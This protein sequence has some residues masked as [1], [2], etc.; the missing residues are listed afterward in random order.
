MHMHAG[1]QDACAHVCMHVDDDVCVR[2]VVCVHP[3]VKGRETEGREREGGARAGGGV[4][5]PLLVPAPRCPPAE[6]AGRC[7][8]DRV[9]P[10]RHAKRMA[11]PGTPLLSLLIHAEGPAPHR[12]RQPRAPRSRAAC[13]Q[14]SMNTRHAG[15]GLAVAVT[16]GHGS[17]DVTMPCTRAKVHHHTDTHDMAH[18]ATQ[19]D[20]HKRRAL[21]CSCAAT[22]VFT[23]ALSAK[24][25]P[26]QLSQ[27][28]SQPIMYLR[29][30]AT[31]PRGAG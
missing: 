15:K 18:L 27:H 13:R 5:A 9:R 14:H 16:P 29:E 11:A 19:D 26:D 25:A 7:G 24:R 6:P 20:Q 31:T 17:I 3:C 1:T 2:V 10:Q 8:P 21:C 28:R 4:H 30:M 22:V 23:L 12:V